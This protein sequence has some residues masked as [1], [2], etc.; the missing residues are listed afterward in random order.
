MLNN[1]YYSFHLIF[2]LFIHTS[3]HFQLSSYFISHSHIFIFCHIYF[4][5]T[6]RYVSFYFWLLYYFLLFYPV[7]Y[8]ELRILSIVKLLEIILCIVLYNIMYINK[9][10]ISINQSL[11]LRLCLYVSVYFSVST[12]L[13][14]FLCFYLPIFRVMK[15][16]CRGCGGMRLDATGWRGRR[17][18]VGCGG[19]QRE[20]KTDLKTWWKYGE[21]YDI[22][23]RNLL[24]RA[25]SGGMRRLRVLLTSI[26]YSTYLY[27]YTYIYIYTR[28]VPPYSIRSST[29]SSN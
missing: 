29:P 27:I 19:M 12:S 10:L 28:G 21:F 15:Q 17:D 6:L 26:Y 16:A 25:L 8:L 1:H 2:L 22:L 11:P 9:Y 5:Y 3:T 23:R 20:K 18:P 14:L 7:Y 13:P 4:C 24:R